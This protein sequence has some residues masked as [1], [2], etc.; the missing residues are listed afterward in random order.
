M[1]AVISFAALEECARVDGERRARC[2]TKEEAE[3]ATGRDARF[4]TDRRPPPRRVLEHTDPPRGHEHSRPCVKEARNTLGFVSFAVGTFENAI[5][6]RDVDAYPRAIVS[7][8]KSE[9][10]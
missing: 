3:E 6:A 7:R 8:A 5:A 2:A 9:S 10:R 1:R 4:A